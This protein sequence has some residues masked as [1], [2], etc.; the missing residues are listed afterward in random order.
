MTSYF[1]E[2]ISDKTLTFYI[3]LAAALLLSRIPLIGKYF[4]MVN[5]VVH[6]SGHALLTLFLSG[7]VIEINL[8]ADTS[9]NV[10]SKARSKFAKIMVGMAGYPFSSGFALLFLYLLSRNSYTLILILITSLTLVLLALALRNSY[11]IFWA[12]TFSLLNFLVLLDNAVTAT[13][14][15]ALFYTLIIF[16]DSVISAVYLLV[17]SIRTPKKAG[18]ASVLEKNSSV[19]AIIWSLV[20]VIIAGIFAYLSVTHYFPHVKIPFV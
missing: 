20:F 1:K 17:L 16:T 2:I 9:G 14:L 15:L 6:E 3:V 5:T 18:D 19:P 12:I 10:V 7:E 4:R 11:G 13:Y 8:F